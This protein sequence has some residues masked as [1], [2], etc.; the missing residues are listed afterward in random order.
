MKKYSA[1]IQKRLDESAVLGKEIFTNMGS[2]EFK[3]FV[4]TMSFIV[5][6]LEPIVK[7]WD[8]LS[9]ESTGKAAKLFVKEN[10]FFL[11]VEGFGVFEIKIDAKKR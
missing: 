5:S 3:A 8:K 11:S 4:S 7:N 2:P 10:F 6:E 1:T 9:E